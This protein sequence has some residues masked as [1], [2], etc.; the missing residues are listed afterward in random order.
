MLLNHKT[1]EEI[2]DFCGYDLQEIKAVQ[3][4]MLK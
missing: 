2:A 4:K 3:E 1:P